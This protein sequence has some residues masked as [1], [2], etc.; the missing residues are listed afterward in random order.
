ME[1]EYEPE[2]E[3]EELF[4]EEPEYAREEDIQAFEAEGEPELEAEEKVLE[5]E[6]AGKVIKR[7]TEGPKRPYVLSKLQLAKLLT[8]RATEIENGAPIYVKVKKGERP[9]P[10]ATATKEIMAKKLPWKIRTKMPD[11]SIQYLPLKDME[12]PR[13][14]R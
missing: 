2:H 10:L 5:P 1:E 7:R 3:Q 6:K 4:P 12:I 8:A 11:G 9:E 13:D 14:I